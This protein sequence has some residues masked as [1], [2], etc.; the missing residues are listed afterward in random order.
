MHPEHAVPQ[1]GEQPVAPGDDANQ[2]PKPTLPAEPGS[3][4]APDPNR[5]SAVGHEEREI[6]NEQDIPSDGVD[7][8][9]EGMIRHL[10]PPARASARIAG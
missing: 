6:S 3:G 5:Q 2:E 10:K 8:L 9:G 7:V 4:R 1:E